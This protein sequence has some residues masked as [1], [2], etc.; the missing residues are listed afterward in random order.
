[1]NISNEFINMLRDE[2]KM[3]KAVTACHE[4]GREEGRK[5]KAMEV[6]RNA[7]AEGFPIET[8]QK[9]TGIDMKS[10]Q[11]IQAEEIHPFILELLNRG[12]TAEE[13]KRCLLQMA[14]DR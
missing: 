3:E 10:I 11:N 4:E 14:G 1:M 13:M 5:E 2:W 12:L 9:I 6:A 8:V 7:L